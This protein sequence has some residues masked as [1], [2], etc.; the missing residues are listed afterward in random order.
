MNK[1]RILTSLVR[2]ALFGAIGLVTF[3]S[4]SATTFEDYEQAL[5]AYNNKRYEESFVHLKNSLK[6]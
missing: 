6:I 2:N 3:T 4:A 1:Q 5:D